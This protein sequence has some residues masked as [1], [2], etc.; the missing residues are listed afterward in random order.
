MIVS[1]RTRENTSN[2]KVWMNYKD[3]AY[4]VKLVSCIDKLISA[5]KTFIFATKSQVF[6]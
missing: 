2:I 4:I 3:H 6:L 1:K 5:N